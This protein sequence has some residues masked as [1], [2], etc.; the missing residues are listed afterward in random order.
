MHFYFIRKGLI[1]NASARNSL[2]LLPW[3]QYCTKHPRVTYFSF[4][5]G[6]FEGGIFLLVI[7]FFFKSQLKSNKVYELE[8]AVILQRF[9]Y[10]YC[11]PNNTNLF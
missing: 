6:W 7:F 4:L 8:I 1:H 5:L 10:P 3:K 2:P 11:Q 9:I